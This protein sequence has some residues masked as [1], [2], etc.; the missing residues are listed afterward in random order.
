VFAVM[1][2]NKFLG[3]YIVHAITI[4]PW[5]LGAFI[6][7]APVFLALS[8][9]LA[10]ATAL[11]CLASV[12]YVRPVPA[13]PAFADALKLM[14]PRA[15]YKQCSLGGSLKSVRDSKTLLSY[16][17]HGMLTIGFSWNGCHAPEFNGKRIIWLVVD[18][19]CQAPLFGWVVGWMGNIQGA[20]ARNMKQLMAAGTNV[21][22]LPGGFEEATIQSFGVE[23][24]YIKKRKGF[25]KYA[26]QYGYRV[27]P[28]YT[29]GECDSFIT[30]T[31]FKKFRLWLNTFK[32]PAVLF[33]GSVF[34][35]LF[36]RS[37][38]SIN[39][40]I[41]EPIVFPRIQSPSPEDVNK[42]HGTYIV[43][44]EALFDKHKEEVGKGHLSLQIW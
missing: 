30:F 17:P 34:C 5:L 7:I 19:L 14:N 36:P 42:W 11:L 16:H 29:F 37:S 32:L 22:L 9:H 41:G 15:Y 31:A 2:R 3:G 1:L 44:L 8:G 28:C 13:W 23:S 43:A 18:V 10:V 25:I 4:F 33:I 24:V 27:H 6:V 20:S 21:A 39:T 38:T 40:F 35:P 12:Q 26:L